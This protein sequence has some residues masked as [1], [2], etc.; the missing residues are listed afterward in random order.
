[1]PF[2][3]AERVFAVV[4]RGGRPDLVGNALPRVGAPTLLIVGGADTKVPG[5]NRRALSQLPDPSELAVVPG[6]THLSEER[7]ALGR[8]TQLAAS[9]FIARLPDNPSS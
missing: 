5:L 7:G 8:V 6:A 9:W 1:M 3:G 4:S 2:H